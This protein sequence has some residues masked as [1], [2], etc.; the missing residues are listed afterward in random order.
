MPGDFLDLSG[1]SQINRGLRELLDAGLLI[2]F[3]QGLYG[4]AKRSSVTGR[5]IPV[6]PLPE[7]AVEALIE[8]L[9]VEVVRS[10]SA[11]RY[12]ARQSKQVPTG[13]VIAVKN[14]VTRKMSYGGITIRLEYVGHSGSMDRA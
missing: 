1:R 12:N 5:L 7:L 3:G 13:R 6:K 14:R 4:K 8:K 9:N 2:R 11:R 10:S